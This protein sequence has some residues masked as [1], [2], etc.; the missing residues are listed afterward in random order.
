MLNNWK[1]LYNLAIEFINIQPWEWMY[2]NDIFGVMDPNSKEIG[3]CSIMGN[4]KEFYGMAI[5]PG[6]EGFAS[7][8]AILNQEFPDEA[9]YG[10]HRQKCLRM[11]FGKRDYVSP[12]EMEIIKKIGIKFENKN[13]WPIFKDFSPGLY[14]WQLAEK[15]L[16]FMIT[17]VEQ[18]L[19]IVI[20]FKDKKEVFAKHIP[21]KIFTAVPTKKKKELVW[22]YD[23]IEPEKYIKQTKFSVI[24][25]KDE[26]L[27][28][29]LKQKY[30]K[31]KR[32]EWQ[33][34]YFYSP[35]PVQDNESSRPY[36]PYLFMA[37]DSFS[38]I[39]IGTQLTE[40]GISKDSIF[41]HSLLEFIEK[42][43]Y[44]PNKFIVRNIELTKIL[45]D[46]AKILDIEII[47]NDDMAFLDEAKEDFIAYLKKN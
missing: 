33:I 20:E 9:S 17:A 37:V 14:P 31:N 28:R 3:Y 5:Y 41:R 35:K 6:A 10:I 25:E 46:L 21:D 34:D 7:L 16:P 8:N 45:E 36:F 11:E 39:I 38:A 23:Y 2:D 18:A 30:Q 43:Q 15:D 26:S 24:T 13:F 29:E 22:N 47:L 19:K 4:N 12:E 27:A 32:I 42:H 44:I 1:K 40:H